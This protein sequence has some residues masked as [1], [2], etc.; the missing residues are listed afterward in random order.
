MAK[1]KKL[2]LKIGLPILAVLVI[3]GLVVANFL[4]KKEKTVE[5]TYELSQQGRLVE[6][7]PGTG[8]VQPEVQVK[9]SAN[10]SGR[11]VELRVKE[12]DRVK[13][14]DLLVRLDRER[15]DAVVEQAKSAQKSAEAGLE[16]SKSD[17]RRIT[18]LNQRGMA[19]EADLEGAQA[20]FKLRS[21]DLKQTQATLK[22]AQDDLS[23]TSIYA[24]MDGIVSLLNKELGEIALGATFQETSS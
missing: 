4:R 14:G 9:V 15:Y 19:S 5:V 17:L 22:Q 24:P 20:D 12:G 8:W 6:T 16:R 3:G 13:K 18:E 2:W 10:V 23:K 21:A 11:I 1:K 7:V